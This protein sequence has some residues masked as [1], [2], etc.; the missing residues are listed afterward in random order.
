MDINGESITAI[1]KISTKSIQHLRDELTDTCAGTL[2]G[3]RRNCA[4]S[5]APSQVRCI[6]LVVARFPDST[7]AVT[8][9]CYSRSL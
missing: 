7:S 2:L 4:Q 3:Y 8:V 1:S 6:E 9:A 5:S